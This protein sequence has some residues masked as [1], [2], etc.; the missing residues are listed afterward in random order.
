MPGAHAKLSH[1]NRPNVVI[2]QSR[3]AEVVPRVGTVS[4]CV[5]HPE[6]LPVPVPL[7]RRTR[8]VKDDRIVASNVLLQEAAAHVFAANRGLR[9]A[10]CWTVALAPCQPPH[11]GD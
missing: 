5:E 1:K 10:D 11:R 7:N 8:T 9:L 6:A 4:A 3:L 2:L